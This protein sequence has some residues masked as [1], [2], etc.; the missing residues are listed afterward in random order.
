MEPL[1]RVYGGPF[2]DCCRHGG[3][4]SRTSGLAFDFDLAPS[5]GVSFDLFDVPPLCAV[6]ACGG[7]T[8]AAVAGL[9][10]DAD[11]GLG[12]VPAA[13][14][15]GLGVNA[16]AAA[17]PGVGAVAATGVAAV[18]APAEPSIKISAA[19]VDSWAGAGADEAAAVA[20]V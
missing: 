1:A 10:A 7:L 18:S 20:R 16:G 14:F 12:A 5:R 6:S 15:S 13:D 4:G 3:I 9:R 11:P 8:T 2:E 17:D 19:D